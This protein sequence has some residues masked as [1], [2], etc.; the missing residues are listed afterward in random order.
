MEE[1]SPDLPKGWVW[2]KVFEAFDIV[3]G[4]TPSTAIGEY[5]NG[6]IPW[7][8][9]ADISNLGIEPRRT[10]NDQAIRNSATNLVPEG[11]I[12]IAT[13]VGLGKIGLASMPLCF[14]QDCHGLIF[15]KSYINPAYALY[16]LSKEIQV[17]KHV[18]RGTTIS[19]V[20]KKQ[21]TELKFPLPPIHEQH[22]IVTKIEELFTNLDSGI[23][24]LKRV[25]AQIKRYRQ[26]VLKQAFE[27]KL[28]A[29]WRE[30]NKDQLEPV[31]GRIDETNREGNSGPLPGTTKL[32]KL[33][34]SWQWVKVRDIGKT[35][36]GNTPSKK[37]EKYYSN[38]KYPFFKPTDL[39]NGYY[40]T[41]SADG[42]SVEGILEAR[43][44]P[45]KSILV[46]CI[47]AT[48]GKT[49][50]I[51]LEG[52]SN[53]Q[54]NAIVTYNNIIPEYIYFACTSTMF[55]KS[56]HDNAS[57]TTL[58]ILN[59]TKFEN[60]IFPM[61][62]YLEQQKIVEEIEHRF[63]IA[64]RVEEM[65]EQNLRRAEH[66]RQSILKKAFAGKLVPQDP[67]DEPASVL[68]ERIRVEKEKSASKEKQRKRSKQ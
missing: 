4:G 21:L 8:T 40:V 49:G 67:T 54:I 46:T 51:R 19:G 17:F 12:I 64:D 27:G 18:K 26:A 31:S 16:S 45:K 33:P 47:G 25:Q 65:V 3:G 62:S 29:G 39:N 15:N 20:T 44:L 41:D 7:I 63:S 28:T 24:N 35:I 60:L 66:L 13:R 14:N 6:I 52:A 30:A 57:S 53:Q 38:K 22:R 9:S 34:P 37:I 32:P 50:F 59:K 42:L 43:P 11:S 61:C 48:I 10:I 23:E 68:L 56:I 58:P 36:T 2:A 55:Q 1:K 5:W